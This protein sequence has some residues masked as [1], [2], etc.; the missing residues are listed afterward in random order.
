MSSSEGVSSPHNE[1]LSL[2]ADKPIEFRSMFSS[3][4]NRKLER[5]IPSHNQLKL[6]LNQDLRPRGA[7]EVLLRTGES[8]WRMEEMYTEVEGGET[9]AMW[10]PSVANTAAGRSNSKTF[11]LGPSIRTMTVGAYALP[12]AVAVVDSVV[13][14][15]GFEF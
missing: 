15:P 7:D 8:D 13:S 9:Y 5:S 11:T 4:N 2:L 12:S 10:K 6:T 1:M 3:R 14:A